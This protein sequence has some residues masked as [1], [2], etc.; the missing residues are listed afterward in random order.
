MDFHAWLQAK[1]FEV[2]ALTEPQRLAL[3]AAWRAESNLQPSPAPVPA[4]TPAPVAEKPSDASF[5]ATMKAIEAENDRIEHIQASTVHYC[6]LNLGDSQK[7]AQIRQLAD[8]AIHDKNTSKKDFDMSMM[9]LDRSGPAHV[10]TRSK[11]EVTSS[12][13]EASVC[14]AGGLRDIEKAYDARTLEVANQTY[15][16]G[17][18]L[19]EL[20]GYCAQRNGFRGTPSRNLKD[21]LRAAFGGGDMMASVGPSTI[22]IDGILSNVAN[23]FVREAFLHV[24]ST[25]RQITAIRSVRD[26]KQ[27]SSYSLTGDLQYEKVAPGGE[28]KHGTLGDTSYNNQV[29]TYGKMLG[30]DR[31]DLVNDDLGA[32]SQVSRRLGR[33]G[34][35]KM[36]DV[37]W[38]E[39][40]DNSSFFSTG[41]GNYDE[42]TDTALTNDGLVAADILWAAMTDPDGKPMG[43]QARY[44]VVPKNLWI[45]AWRLMNST[46]F[47]SADEEGERNPWANK[48]EIVTSDYLNNTNYT[49]YSTKAWYL[50]RDPMDIPVIE[51]AFL[52]GV[53]MPTIESADLDFNRLGIAFR[54]YHDFGVALQEPRGGY[55]FKGEA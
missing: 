47:T 7:V 49:G 34:A 10:F 4:P 33:G 44:M 11:P 16:R 48:F 3:Q 8:A 40:M 45:P 53:E 9:L 52:N 32:L 51:T 21:A 27:I 18:G 43:G 24:E 14:M 31:R 46:N 54:A 5:D 25:W 13:L 35:L 12:V 29:D 38:T 42:G 36:N 50:L 22:S 19:M 26:F 17:I 2:A 20:V 15:G 6:Q 23:K 1:G 55:K 39:F 37:F 30:L 41:N 28:I